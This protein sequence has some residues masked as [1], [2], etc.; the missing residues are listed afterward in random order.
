M[1]ISFGPAAITDAYLEQEGI[2]PYLI[3]LQTEVTKLAE[4]H[5]KSA[6]ASTGNFEAM[7]AKLDG[8]DKLIRHGNKGAPATVTGQG[9]GTPAAHSTAVNHLIKRGPAVVAHATGTTPK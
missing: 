2:I 7:Q 1:S 3:Q 5:E 6:G 4:S 9:M 8:L